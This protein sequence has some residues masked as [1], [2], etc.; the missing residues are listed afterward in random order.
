LDNI[1]LNLRNTIVYADKVKFRLRGGLLSGFP[2]TSIL[3]S[4]INLF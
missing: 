2:L 4:I 3:G 1:I